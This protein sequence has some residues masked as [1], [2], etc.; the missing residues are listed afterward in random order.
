MR[1]VWKSLKHE[2]GDTHVKWECVNCG[3]RDM[4]NWHDPCP[5]R[6]KK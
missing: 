5:R 4:A 1:H 3:E 2:R 6:R